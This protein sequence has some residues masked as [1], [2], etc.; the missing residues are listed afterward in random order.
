MLTIFGTPKAFFG[1]TAVDQTNAIISWKMMLPEAQ[2]I[3]IGDDPGT[4]SVAEQ[5]GVS[6]VPGVATN[7]LGTPRLD[8]IFR[9][10]QKNAQYDI[11]MYINADIV[12]THSLATHMG[13]LSA[14]FKDG[15]NIL[16]IGR[17]W[18]TKQKFVLK[19][20]NSDLNQFYKTI[21]TAVSDSKLH[22][23][24]GLDYFI[25]NKNSFRLP[26]F[27]IGRPCWDNWL[28][29]HCYKNKFSIIDC[30]D[31]LTVLH[32][33]HDYSHSAS[34]GAR[35][36]LGHE[37]DHNVRVAG[38][39]RNQENLLCVT[40]RLTNYGVVRRSFLRRFCFYV[41]SHSPLKTILSAIRYLRYRRENA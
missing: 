6:H 21:S 41:F 19:S 7:D 26:A 32:Q 18:D 2:I 11:L 22:G 23:R 29:W 35:R 37:W 27:L 39:Y 24:S 34:G 10:A 3:L 33:D 31:T 40:H 25:F 12:F 38:G 1:Q 9:I 16:A 8:D 30:T 13:S 5:L 14:H 20:D 15:N 4:S 28:L 17:R 36:V